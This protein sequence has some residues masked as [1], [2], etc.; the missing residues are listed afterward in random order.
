M[1][2]PTMICLMA[3]SIGLIGC[4]DWQYDVSIEGL[5]FSQVKVDRDGFTIGLLAR[6]TAIGDRPCKRGWV[7][8]HP[9]GVIAA[10]T[11]AQP[12]PFGKMTIPSDTWIRQ[13]ERGIITLC[14][15]PRAT[16]VQGHWCRGTGGPKGVQTAFYPSG[17]L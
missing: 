14:A 1:N 6:E 7:H 13:D 5:A 12:V 9:N 17:A 10:F 4:S 8:I 15:F 11:A 2:M 16:E 3:G